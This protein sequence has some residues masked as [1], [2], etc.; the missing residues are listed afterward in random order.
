V[1]LWRRELAIVPRED[2]ANGARGKRGCGMVPLTKD[3]SRLYLLY[4]EHEYELLDSDYVFVNR[5]GGEHGRPLSYA[6][7]SR[8]VARTRRRVG[9]DFTPHDFRHTFVSLARRGGVR[10]EVISRL[11]THPSRLRQTSTATWSSRTS[12]RSSR[13][14]GHLSRSSR[15]SGE[16]GAACA[17]RGLGA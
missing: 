17:R 14:V 2:N 4:M 12:A 10:L 11:V 15:L 16:P 1:R 8:L 9:F 3:A 7:V 13:R 5:W 6:A